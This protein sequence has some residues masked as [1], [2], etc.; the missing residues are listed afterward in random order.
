V[1]L[2]SPF[3]RLVYAHM[4][5]IFRKSRPKLPG[6]LALYARGE[7]AFLVNAASYNV[8]SGA[9]PFVP[10]GNPTAPEQI[11]WRSP[12]ALVTELRGSP[13]QSSRASFGDSLFSFPLEARMTLNRSIVPGGNSTSKFHTRQPLRRRLHGHSLTVP[14]LHLLKLQTLVGSRRR[15]LVADQRAIRIQLADSVVAESEVIAQDPLIV[16]T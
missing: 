5:A 10:T 12:L 15:A 9:K 13:H 16:L 2:S 3:L 11:V 6:Q 7:L 1:W 8:R 14:E 4:P